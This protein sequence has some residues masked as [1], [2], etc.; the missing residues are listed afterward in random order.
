VSEANF[1]LQIPPTANDVTAAAQPNP[2]GTQKVTVPTLNGNDAEDGTLQGGVGNTVKITT[3][4]TNAKLYYDGTEITDV[5]TV[6]SDYDPTLLKIDPND[7]AL[8]AIFKYREIDAAGF[9][10]PEATVTMPFTEFAI[11][12]KVY[13]DADGT[14]NG[15]IDGTLIGSADATVL[16][17]NLVEKSSGMVKGWSAITAGGVYSF[18]TENGLQTNTVFDL[19]LSSVKGVVGTTT[20]ATPTLPSPWV[21]TAESSGTGDGLANGILQVS[22]VASNI[23]SGLDFGIEKLPTPGSGNNFVLNPLG[24]A[25]LTVPANTFT[26]AEKS[27]DPDGKVTSIKSRHSRL[28]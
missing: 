23:N 3:L 2:G 12:G 26:N 5:N 1:G 17:V 6:I 13:H 10:S 7:G 16:Y 8:T 9:I 19:V 15:L 21:N 27:A 4:P 18:N 25:N 14:T 20:G 22:V 11:T 28:M 24:T